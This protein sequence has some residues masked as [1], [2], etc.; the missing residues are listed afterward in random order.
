MSEEQAGSRFLVDTHA[1]L[2]HI[3]ERLGEKALEAL[4]DAWRRER[5]ALQDSGGGEAPFLI[6]IGVDPEDFLVRKKRFGALPWV[7]MAA[8]AWPG[9]GP[10]GDRGECPGRGA[11]SRGGSSLRGGGRM[12]LGLLS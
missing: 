12:R 1:H 6:D 7:R 8:G 10:C 11:R 4:D 5:D 2:S 9:A 3:V